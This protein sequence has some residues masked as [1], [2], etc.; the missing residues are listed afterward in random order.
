MKI[1]KCAPYPYLKEGCSLYESFDLLGKSIYSPQIFDNSVIKNDFSD[2]RIILCSD[3]LR[4]IQTANLIQKKIKHIIKI[5][6]TN[7]L[8][9]VAHAMNQFINEME[10]NNNGEEYK[11]KTSSEIKYFNVNIRLA[12]KRFI[13]AFVK[14]Q[15]TESKESVINRIQDLLQVLKELAKDN[16]QILCISHGFFIRIMQLIHADIN[17]LN[18]PLELVK[19]FNPN[20]KGCGSGEGFEIDLETI[21]NE[22]RGEIK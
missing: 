16:K 3:T 22:K 11:I 18:K 8:R 21:N 7:L 5:I 20:T 17:I 15:L 6:P 19:L 1:I 4:A 12:R 14:N 9:E 2:V 13:E 10:F